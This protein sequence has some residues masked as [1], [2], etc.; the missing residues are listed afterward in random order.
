MAD[1][2][3]VSIMNMVV[4]EMKSMWLLNVEAETNGD[5]ETI[6]FLN[7]ALGDIALDFCTPVQVGHSEV[8]LISLFV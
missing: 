4:D 8:E 7:P 3:E 2:I 1:G 6:S 5:D